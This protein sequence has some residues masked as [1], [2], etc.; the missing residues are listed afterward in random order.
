MKTPVLVKRLAVRW[1][2]RL[3]LHDAFISLGCT[4][5]LA[6]PQEGNHMT[7]LRSPSSSHPPWR[8]LEQGQLLREVRYG[9]DVEVVFVGGVGNVQGG[10]HSSLVGGSSGCASAQRIT[11]SAPA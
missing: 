8:E 9:H 3:D 10:D 2:R 6:V 5:L 7:A 11:N 1:E 4:H